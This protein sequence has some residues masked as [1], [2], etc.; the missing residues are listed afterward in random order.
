MLRRLQV[1][2]PIPLHGT[3]ITDE[4]PGHPGNDVTLVVTIALT[5][6]RIPKTFRE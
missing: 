6:Q 3:R 4:T 2:Q 5:N 1:E